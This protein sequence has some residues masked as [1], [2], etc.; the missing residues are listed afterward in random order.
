MGVRQLPRIAERLIAARPRRPDEPAAVVE[1][2]TLPGQRTVRRARSRR[3]PSAPRRRQV[4][5]PV[6]HGRRR[7]SPRCA[8]E[9]AWLERAAAAR[10][11]A[12]PSRARARR[13]AAWRAR[14][15]AL[16]AEVVEAPAIRIEPLAGAERARPV[17]ATTSICADE[18][19]RR[20]GCCSS[21]SPPPAA[22]R[23][24]S[25]AR[26]SPRSARARRAR[27]ARTASSPTW[28]PSASVAEALVEALARRAGRSARWSRAP[29]EARDV[30]PDALRE[31]GA[32]V[33]VLALYETVA[34]PLDAGDARGRARR[35]TTSPSP[36][37]RPCAS[38]SR[39]RR[40]TRSPHGARSSRSARS[41]ATSC[42][43]TAWR[44]TSRRAP[45]R[46]RA[47]RGAGRRRLAGSRTTFAG[48]ER[49][50][51]GRGT[52]APSGPCPRS[53]SGPCRPC[54]RP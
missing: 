39:R 16:G 51:C 15:R 6:D 21:G 46:R 52:R 27:C 5:P 33:D 37:P 13:R 24:R 36:P 1:R 49:P 4:R 20:R 50:S 40:P 41:R 42:A 19:Q 17:A 32:E 25:P 43:S 45:R 7:R 22:T 10:A 14:L 53:R 47:G 18:P 2:G 31:R 38:S 35:P 11:D 9:L 8:S 12:S 26:R 3:S 28:C 34:E 54:G 30:L 29:R 23:A 44:P 48:P